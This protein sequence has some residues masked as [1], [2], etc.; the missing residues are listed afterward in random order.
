MEDLSSLLLKS[1]SLMTPAQ[2]LKRVSSLYLD[3][4]KMIELQIK[5]EFKDI[6]SQQLKKQ[7]AMKMYCS[8]PVMIELLNRVLPDEVVCDRE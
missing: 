1:L 8:D 2:K 5:R 4:K 3:M 7:I 6:S